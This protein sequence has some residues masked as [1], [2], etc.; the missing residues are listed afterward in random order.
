MAKQVRLDFGD[1]ETWINNIA[2]T[3][4]EETVERAVR[5]LK[6]R[7]PYWTGEFERAWKV[8][9][10]QP[11]PA[12][13]EPDPSLGTQAERISNGA[14]PPTITPLKAG[15]DFPEAPKQSVIKYTIGNEMTYR[16]VAQDLEPGRIKGGGN[17]TAQQDWYVKYIQTGGL[18]TT[19]ALAANR[20]SKDPKIK[21]FK[22]NLNK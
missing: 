13:K 12:T 17:E 22:G 5:Q 14:Q 6:I 9:L 16:N 8:T 10:G 7:G 4:A 1:L 19:I 21:N 18:A 3:T 2:S 15:R 11:I 20:T